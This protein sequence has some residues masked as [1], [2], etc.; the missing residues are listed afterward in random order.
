MY[1][2]YGRVGTVEVRGSTR[3]LPV[4]VTFTVTVISYVARFGARTSL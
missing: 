4:T 3:M 2:Y 1:A